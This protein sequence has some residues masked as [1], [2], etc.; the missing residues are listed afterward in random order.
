MTQ[1]RFRADLL[2]NYM[3]SAPL[4]LAFE[5]YLEG[6]ILGQVPFRRPVLDLGCGDGLFAHLLFAE[7]IDTGIDPNPR[8][9]ERARQRR[10]YR[11]LIEGVGSAVPKPSGAYQTIFS[12]SALEHIPVLEPVF[13]EVHRLLAPGGRLYL[14]VPSPLFEQFTVLNALLTGSRLERLAARYRR[15]GSRGLW[16]QQHYHTREEWQSIA[17]SHGFLPIDAFTYD[18]RRICLLNDALYPLAGMSLLSKGVFDRWVLWP[19]LR[20]L[21]MRPLSRIVEGFLEGGLRA[22][23]GGLVFLALEKG[24]SR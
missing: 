6:R 13:R 10:C 9:L 3:S 1:V 16:R 22:D 20:R 7:P 15:F 5:R 4:A 19:R 18:P 12:N 2:L 17:E 8:E 11:E 23:P 21:T 24:A 14:T